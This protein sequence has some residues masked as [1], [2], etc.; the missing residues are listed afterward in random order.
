MEIIVLPKERVEFI[1]T[2]L[3]EIKGILQSK[4]PVSKKENW[5][6]KSEACERLRVCGK[7]LDSY[8]KKGVIPFSQFK[9]K[10]YIKSVDV[11]NH[12]EKYH[13]IKK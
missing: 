5:I 9:S 1:E 3:S 11:D 6:S 10:I 4:E 13:V 7:T 12:L 8:L 2:S